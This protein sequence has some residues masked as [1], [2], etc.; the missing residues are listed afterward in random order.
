MQ[1]TINSHPTAPPKFA[2]AVFCKNTSTQNLIHNRSLIEINGKSVLAIIVDRLKESPHVSQ[3]IVATTPNK[4]DDS[5][6]QKAEQ[7]GLP[8]F[9]GHDI[10]IKRVA[11]IMAHYDA[12][13]LIKIHGNYPLVDI[14][15]MDQLVKEYI[16]KDADFTYNGHQNGVL[17]G[18]D[19]EIINRRLFEK[20]NVEAL[21]Q[22]EYQSGTLFLRLRE[23]E[24]NIHKPNH[25]EARKEYKVCI[26][27]KKDVLLIEEI[28]NRLPTPNMDN[29]VR[30]L[31]DNEFLR[32]MNIHQNGAKEIGVE[33]ILHFPQKTAFYTGNSPIDISYPISVELSLTDACNQ[34]C[35]WCSDF[36]LR[37]RSNSFLSYET[38]YNL[39]DD[40]QEGGTR[41]VVIEGGG[42]PTLHPQFNKIIQQLIHKKMDFGLITNGTRL[43]Y[44]DY[45]DKFSWVRV[46]LDAS[47]PEEYQQ[48]KGGD[49]FD[50]VI[51]HIRI[52]A[53]NVKTCGVGYVVTNRNL[54]NIEDL[55][56]RL[57]CLDVSYIHFRPVIDHPQL[58]TP[59]KLLFLKKYSTDHFSILLDAMNENAVTGN[60]GVPCLAHSLSSVIC[61]DGSVYLCGRLNKYD[62][63]KPIGNINRQS[64]KEIWNGDERKKQIEQVMS[65]EF[66][67]Q[68]CPPCRMTKYN[69]L[70]DRVLK[71]KTRNFI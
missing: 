7:L 31:D 39:L 45:L 17:Y 24:I 30:L 40:L 61:G 18:M 70:M 49:M 2:V 63:W 13:H 14:S 33:K 11:Q 69:T 6:A 22:T 41:G 65:G 4:E 53:Q 55:V 68:N 71:V 54:G 29:V 59:E 50:Q 16:E 42:E 1:Y 52:L 57:K 67:S 47:N 8:C 10:V 34:E 64:F 66:C 44:R 32:T 19:A 58:S 43:Q 36:P 5:I 3:I 28:I 56:L 51:E 60:D 12:S 20:I 25:P 37:K 15:L 27:Y 9:R 48:L 23:K 38:F 21:N 62:W 35:I 26:E 46:S